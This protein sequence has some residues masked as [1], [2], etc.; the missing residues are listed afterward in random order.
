MTNFQ[1]KF[2]SVLAGFLSLIVF[3]A[4]MVGIY[5][6]ADHTIQARDQAGLQQRLIVLT[7]LMSLPGVIIA[8]LL[9]FTVRVATNP[10]TR[11]L[12]PSILVGAGVGIT[13][14]AVANKVE[15][16]AAQKPRIRVPLAPASRKEPLPE[17]AIPM[18]E[19]GAQ[20]PPVEQKPL[21]PERL[22]GQRLK[23]FV[24]SARSGNGR[25]PG[26]DLFNHRRPRRRRG[27]SPRLSTAPGFAGSHDRGPDS[28]RSEQ[29]R[30]ERVA[31]RARQHPR[32]G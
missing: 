30:L 9:G 20:L 17:G 31:E 14:R 12:I 27:N 11:W 29:Q 3:A 26:K 8:F 32:T 16:N 10:K 21:M 25:Q 24:V 2:R 28:N 5:L 18:R 1:S 15:A 13:F 6:D 22:A 7:V 19:A 23:E 4:I